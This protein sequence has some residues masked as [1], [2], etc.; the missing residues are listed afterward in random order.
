MFYI[1]AYFEAH[2]DVYYERLLAIT[3]ENDW[4]G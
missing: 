2:R 1:S 4:N 3:R